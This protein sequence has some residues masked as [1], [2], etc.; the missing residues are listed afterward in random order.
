MSEAGLAVTRSHHADQWLLAA[1]LVVAF[2]PTWVDLGRHWVE[3]PWARYALV[4][5]PLA[6]VAARRAPAAGA[7]SGLGW[8]GVGLAVE[9]AAAFAGAIRWARPGLALSAFGWLRRGDFAAPR[10]ATL[11]FFAVP[12]PAFL[13]RSAGMGASSLS[14]VPLLAGIAWY[15]GCLFRRSWRSTALA[16]GGAAL[17]ALPLALAVEVAKRGA[18][19][20]GLAA[21]TAAALA[22]WLWLPVAVCA[23]GW[24]E[25]RWWRRSP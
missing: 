12:A 16:C 6:A 13:L 17:A 15:E 22:G 2:S 1:G 5:P 14:L 23:L 20:A 3:T 11:L 25:L 18:V 24:V 4:F 19:E 21:S 9:L 7:S 10:A 8:I